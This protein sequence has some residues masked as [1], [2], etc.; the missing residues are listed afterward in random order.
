MNIQQ[1]VQ[2]ISIGDDVAQA[3]HETIR[4]RIRAV[5]ILLSEKI[6]AAQASDFQGWTLLSCA[7][8]GS[9]FLR[10][11][12]LLTWER[13]D[14]SLAEDVDELKSD[15]PMGFKLPLEEDADEQD[16]PNTE[17]C[18]DESSPQLVLNVGDKFLVNGVEFLIDGVIQRPVSTQ[19]TI[20]PVLNASTPFFRRYN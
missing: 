13:E 5:E 4:Q 2:Y 7:P 9:S 18:S 6:M 3:A 1:R 12:Y 8:A 16:A 15:E 10:H 14:S 11:T 20:K 17:S 19:L